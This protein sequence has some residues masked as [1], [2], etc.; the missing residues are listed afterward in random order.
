[1]HKTYEGEKREG[2]KVISPEK[3]EGVEV[4]IFPFFSCFGFSPLAS[5]M[6]EFPEIKQTFAEK[7]RRSTN[8]YSFSTIKINRKIAIFKLEIFIIY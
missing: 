5:G 1:M 8:V 2:G 3:R 4:E 6:E 7:I